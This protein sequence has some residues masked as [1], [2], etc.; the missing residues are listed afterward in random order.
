MNKIKIKK[1]TD[2]GT[3]NIPKNKWVDVEK[4]Y[5]TRDGR[6]VINLQIVLHN[7][8]GNEVTYPV[9]GSIIKRGTSARKKTEYTVWS[10]DGRHNILEK[11]GKKDLVLDKTKK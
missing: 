5:K 9:K 2:W 6:D 4:K 1:Q 10:L 11:N 7:S 8:C 3:D